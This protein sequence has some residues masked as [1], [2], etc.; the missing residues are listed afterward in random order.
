MG[1]RGPGACCLSPVPEAVSVD[2]LSLVNLCGDPCGVRIG[3]AHFLAALH[4]WVTLGCCRQWHWRQG[5]RVDL[6]VQWT[7]VPAGPQPIY[8]PTLQHQYDGTGASTRTTPTAFA[9]PPP[10][11][12][13]PADIMGASCGGADGLHAN[14]DSHGSRPGAGGLHRL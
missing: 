6:T 9:K 10:P 2:S 1:A 3:T 4:Y 8:D 7:A 14:P 13:A 5:K 12:A 11:P